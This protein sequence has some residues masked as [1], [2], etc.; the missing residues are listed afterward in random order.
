MI[1]KINYKILLKDLSIILFCI[2]LSLCVSIFN[3]LFINN[4]LKYLIYLLCIF[5]FGFWFHA[6]SSFLHEAVHYNLH[7][8]KKINDII[9]DVLFIPTLGIKTKQYRK[10]HW[11]HHKNLGTTKDIENSYFTDLSLKNIIKSFIPF[12][13][14]LEK[15]NN[16]T[17]VANNNFRMISFYPFLFAFLFHTIVIFFLYFK[18][19]SY[20]SFVYLISVLIIFPLLAKVRQKLEHRDEVAIKNA[21]YS[22]I[23]HGECNRMFSE[24]FFSRFFGAAG[25]NRHF[26]HH[27]NPTISYTNF[28]QYENYIKDND[29]SLFNKVTKSKTTYYK[30]FLK[31]ISC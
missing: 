24:N 11:E 13:T 3:E 20:T 26:L 28:N 12:F 27:L 5:S 14:I 25:F 21:D 4:F 15:I 23:D 18:N 9:S 30:T 22:I 7:P 8:N 10:Y 29:P 17:K 19:L 1:L 6:F 31:L 16:E 2:F